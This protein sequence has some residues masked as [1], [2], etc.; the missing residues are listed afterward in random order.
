MAM[1]GGGETNEDSF[2]AK[3]VKYIPAEINAAYLAGAGII[4]AASGEAARNT[5]HWVWVVFLFLAAPLWIAVAT[6]EPGK[7]IAWYQTLVA[8]VALIVWVFAMGGP[9][10]QMSWYQ[11]MW[12]SLALIATTILFPILEKVFVRPAAAT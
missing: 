2:I 4:A 1:G 12:G 5:A 11:P 10:E 9:F 3:L 6:R 8:P 7:P